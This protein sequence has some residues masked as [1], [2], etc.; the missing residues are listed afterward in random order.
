MGGGFRGQ[1]TGT[2]SEAGFKG[3]DENDGSDG[4]GVAFYAHADGFGDED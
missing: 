1:G 3:K 2:P 4:G